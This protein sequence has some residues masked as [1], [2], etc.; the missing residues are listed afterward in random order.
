MEEVKFKSRKCAKFLN[1]FVDDNSTGELM[2]SPEEL[3]RQILDM[4]KFLTA[5]MEAPGGWNNTDLST[6]VNASMYGIPDLSVFRQIFTGFGENIKRDS[7]CAACQVYTGVLMHQ[8]FCSW[9]CSQIF[10]EN[11]LMF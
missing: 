6:K 5:Q 10:N 2:L 11:A 1:T 4:H 3:D 8:V 9:Y 7:V